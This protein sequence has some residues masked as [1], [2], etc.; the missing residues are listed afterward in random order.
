MQIGDIAGGSFAWINHHH[1]HIGS[2]LFGLSNSLKQYR[3]TPCGIR[4]NNHQQISLLKIFITA[5]HGITAKGPFMG[6]YCRG[7]T[8]T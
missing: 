5:W 1:F 6:G 3:M 2:I 8:Q 4:T 7:H